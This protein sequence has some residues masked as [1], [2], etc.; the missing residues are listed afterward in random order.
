VDPQ[1]QRSWKEFLDPELTRR[2]LLLA[3]VYIGWFEVMKDLIVRRVCE[4]FC[5]GPDT[6]KEINKR[7]YYSVVLSRNHSPLYASLDWLKEMGAITDA[8]IEAYPA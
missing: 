7:Q 4:F 1:T 3:S 2:R 6:C 8:D 5:S